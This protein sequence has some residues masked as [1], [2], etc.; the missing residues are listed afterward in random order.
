MLGS[1]QTCKHFMFR[2]HQLNTT[3]MKDDMMLTKSYKICLWLK[4][5]SVIVNGAVTTYL[6]LCSWV[7]P[8]DSLSGSPPGPLLWRVAF[9]V[10]MCLAD[11]MCDSARMSDNWRNKSQDE[12]FSVQVI[13]IFQL[14]RSGIWPQCIHTWWRMFQHIHIN[15]PPLQCISNQQF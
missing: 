10:Q 11:C 14:L 9:K 6:T 5:E 13:N 1:H 2:S 3:A 7:G 12:I 4:S 8:Q 15:L